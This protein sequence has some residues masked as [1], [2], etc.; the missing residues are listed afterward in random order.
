[1]K[2]IKGMEQQEILTQGIKALY[3][4][5]GPAEA[6][7]FIALTQ[8]R[9]REDS[10]TRHCK[11]QEGLDKNEFLSQM[12]SAYAKARKKYNQSSPEVS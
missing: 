5:L 8:S 10:V 1:M 3:D 4:K 6:R 9:N 2:M 11:W 12:R 7:R